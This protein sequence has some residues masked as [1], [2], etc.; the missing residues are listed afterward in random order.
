MSIPR[1]HESRAVRHRSHCF[2]AGRDGEVMLERLLVGG[3]STPALAGAVIVDG[4][5]L[6]AA[7]TPIHS[8]NAGRDHLG[9]L[10]AGPLV[11]I[12]SSVREVELSRMAVDLFDVLQERGEV[13]DTLRARPCP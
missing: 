12:V 6:T 3:E 10:I 1:T 13:E 5:T 4:D 2:P 11:L 8:L 7:R 9:E